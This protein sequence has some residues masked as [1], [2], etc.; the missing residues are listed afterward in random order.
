MSDIILRLMVWFYSLGVQKRFPVP[1]LFKEK[2]YVVVIDC[3][4]CALIRG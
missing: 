3:L 2:Q 4:E 1:K